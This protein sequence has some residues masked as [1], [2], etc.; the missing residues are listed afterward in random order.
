M[1]F[2]SILVA[3]VGFAFV[4]EA[5]ITKSYRSSKLGMCIF[6]YKNKENLFSLY[7]KSYMLGKDSKVFLVQT[8]KVV[9][10]YN[11]ILGKLP[12]VLIKKGSYLL[13]YFMHKYHK[14]HFY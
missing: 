2:E 14:F 11:Y 5:M 7:L 10:F 13:D 12:Q 8:C 9:M 4:V 1:S 3:K 6:S